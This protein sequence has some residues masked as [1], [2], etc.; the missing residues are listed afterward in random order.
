MSIGGA[1]NI[2]GVG[3]EGLFKSKAGGGLSAEALAW[4]ARII[5]NGGTIPAA[6]LKIF[7]DNF[8]KPA[9]A[10]GN[11]LT[12]L[13]RLN[14]YC[15]L[16]GFEIAARTN[17]IKS[18][19]YVTPVSSPHFTNN[20][21][22]TSGTSYLDLNYNP[23]TQAVKLTQNSITQFV[24]FKN[25]NFSGATRRS[26]GALSG[27]GA[28]RLEIYINDAGLRTAFN[29]QALATQSTQTPSGFV[30]VVGKRSA[31]NTTLIKVNGISTTGATVS[32]IL[33][34]AKVFELTTSNSNTPLGDY[35]NNNHFASGHGSNN[36][37]DSALRTI[38]DNL[39]TALGV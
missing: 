14:V 24:V 25:P 31:I 28:T 1:F 18:A 33:A 6:T 12:E 11:I 23:S 15:G 10:N 4:E 8:F 5:A 9:V 32:T 19:H 2:I 34:N 27:G 35:D 17:M 39:F 36:C 20:G 38:L 21:Y 22:R 30:H 26:M 13:D 37:D 16:V 3:P 29:S 7:D